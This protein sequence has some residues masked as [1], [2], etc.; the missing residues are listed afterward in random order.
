MNRVFD[1][2]SLVALGGVLLACTTGYLPWAVWVSIISLWPLLLVS[3]G[4][5]L[6]GKATDRDWLRALSSVV[7][8]AGLLYGALVMPAGSWGPSRMIGSGGPVY[9]HS[10]PHDA[11]V[12]EG[13]AKIQA[14][15]T[16]MTLVA[17]PRLASI[18][19]EAP[20]GA[21]PELRTTS[22]DGVADVRVE[23]PGGTITIVGPST[24][25][26]L[27]IELDRDVRWKMLEIDAAAAQSDIDVSGLRVDRLTIDAGASD[28]RITVGEN[29]PSIVVSAGAANVT[30]RVPKSARVMMNL[31]G[32]LTAP[33]MPADFTRTHGNG[34]I[35]DAVWTGDGSGASID[36]AVHAGVASVSVQRY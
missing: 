24:R 33:G 22:S 2:L 30:V 29:T 35:G 11:A 10:V 18:R 13:T 15:A 9:S 4:L 25:N 27:D 28:A 26:R 23:G 19:G 5:D 16:R 21:A 14:V 34:F 20:A 17:G 12:T 3:A 7:F 31:S 36:I 6:I 32:A 8:I 1:G